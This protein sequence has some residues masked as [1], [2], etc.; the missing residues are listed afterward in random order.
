MEDITFMDSVT[1]VGRNST[2]STG[3]QGPAKESKSGSKAPA[4]HPTQKRAISFGHR[5]KGSNMEYF[6]KTFVYF[7]T[8]KTIYTR[9]NMNINVVLG[10]S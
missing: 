10:L 1:Y 9:N 8:I 5:T 4:P 2:V 3:H 6:Q 7:M